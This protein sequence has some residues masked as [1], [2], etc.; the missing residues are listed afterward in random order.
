MTFLFEDAGDETQRAEDAR[1]IA[2]LGSLKDRRDDYLRRLREADPKLL[3]RVLVEIQESSYPTMSDAH[4]ARA[5]AQGMLDLKLTEQTTSTMRELSASADRLARVG[6]LLMF[7]A[8]VV[9]FVQL[10]RCA[11]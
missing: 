1:E 10:L 4:S 6:N 7:A 11:G 3:L 2:R 5:C 8:F 9:A